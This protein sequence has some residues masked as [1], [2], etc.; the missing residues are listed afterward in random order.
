MPFFSVII[1]TYNRAGD[2]KR[3]LDSV[4]QQTFTDF[5]VVIVDDG[6]TDDT[7][8]VI[9]TYTDARIKYIYQQNSERSAARNNGIRNASGKYICLLDSD[10]VYYP[11]HLDVL[12][13]QIVKDGEPI[14]VYKTMM[15]YGD[16]SRP[17]DLSYAYTGNDRESAMRYVWTNGSQLI[18]ICFH[19]EI[20]KHV[21]FPEPFFWFEDVHW[22]MRVVSQ[23][24]LKQVN[25]HTT[26]YF[27]KSTINKLKTNYERYL[28]NCEACIRDLE[29]QKGDDIKKLMGRNCF[30]KK[31]AE[32][33]LGFVVAGAIESKQFD[34]AKLFLA[35]AMATCTT[36]KLMVKYVY[37]YWKLIKASVS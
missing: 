20:G 28:N 36:P 31:V 29:K 5:E 17:D 12:H 32:L 27:N 3:S 34:L 26:R 9:Q 23:Y 13:Q 6:S 15:N 35:K 8:Q 1:P 33:Y 16:R 22:L 14:A 24:P 25:A 11:E 19:H 37:Y 21:L 2:L 10:D 7:A 30:N 4:L 18:A